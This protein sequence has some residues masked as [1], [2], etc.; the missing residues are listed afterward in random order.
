LLSG[1]GFKDDLATRPIAPKSLAA[2]QIAGAMIF[3]TRGATRPIAII[4]GGVPHRMKTMWLFA[5]EV[6]RRANNRK[7]PSQW[8][9]NATLKTLND[10]P[11][12]S[13]IADCIPNM[14][15]TIIPNLSAGQ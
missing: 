12:S 1:A 9:K 7:M 4:S 14:A 5:G 3:Q 10:C 15:C 2:A 11:V 13:I 6:G 8:T